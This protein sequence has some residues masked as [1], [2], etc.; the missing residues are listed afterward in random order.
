MGLGD[1]AVTRYTPTLH[2]LTNV[3]GIAAGQRHALALRSD[4]TVWAWGVNNNGQLGFGP[5]PPPPPA[6]TVVSTPGQVEGLEGVTIVAITAGDNHSVAL[7]SEGHVWAWGLNT[8]YQLGDGTTADRNRPVL[9]DGL[10]GIVAIGSGPGSNHN[11]AIRGGDRAVLAWGSNYYGTLGDGTTV[12]RAAPVT[13]I[14][15]TDIVAVG[16][17]GF[18][19]T[20]AGQDGRLWSWGAVGQ[21]GDGS[22]GGTVHQR[23]PLELEPTGITRTSPGNAASSGHALALSNDGVIWSWGYGASH[24]IGDG[25]VGGPSYTRYRPV[26]VTEPGFA[27]KVASPAI[28]PGGTSPLASVVVSM[29]AWVPAGTPAATIR[30]TTNGEEPDAFSDVYAGA[31]TFTQTVAV[32][33]KAWKAGLADSN[34]ETMTYNVEAGMPTFTPSGGTYTTPQSVAMSGTS[35]GAVIRYTTDGSEPDGTSTVYTAPVNLTANTT[36][37]AKA[38]HANMVTSSTRTA[39]YNFNFPAGGAPVFSP[40]PGTSVGSV[41][42]SM[43]GPVGATLQYTTDGTEP[44]VTSTAYSSPLT[45]T[46]TTTLKAKSFQAAQSPS[47]TT[48]GVYTIELAAPTFSPAGGTLTP[49]QAV[50]LNHADP[51]VAIRY[52]INGVDPGPTDAVAAPGSSV[53]LF[54]NATLK[55]RAYK[56]GTEPSAVT[57][58]T[59][60]VSGTAGAAGVLAAGYSHTLVA[61]PDGTVWA[62][63]SNNH[64]KLGDGSTTPRWSPVAIPSLSGVTGLSAGFNHSAARK[65]DGTPWTTGYNSA[66]QLGN[67]TNSPHSTFAGLAKPGGV[68]VIAV[69]AGES[70]TLALGSDGRVWAWGLNSYGQ[71]GNGN[72]APQTTPVLVGGGLSGVPVQAIAAGGDFS[73][74][75]T[76]GGEVWSWG[77]NSEGELGNGGTTSSNVPVQVTTVATTNL[78]GVVGI[79]AGWRH[80]LAR[81]ADGTVWS[82]GMNSEGQLGSGAIG[83]P[84]TRAGQVV[85]LAQARAIGAGRQHSLAVRDDGSVWAW[86]QGGNGQLGNNGGGNQP[87]PVQAIGISG[88]DSVAGGGLFSVALGLDGSV[89]AWGG[90]SDGQLGDGTTASR[91]TPARVSDSNFTWRVGTPQFSP[92]SGA[93]TSAQNVVITTSTAGATIHYTKTGADPSPADPAIASGASVLVDEPVTLKARAYKS[94]WAPSGVATLPFTLTLVSPT[95]TPGAGTY[96]VPQVF[97]ASHPVPGAVVRYT[98]DGSPV[99]ASSPEMP[100]GGVAVNQTMSLSVGAFK[101]GGWAASSQSSYN[102]HMKVGQT[103]HGTAGGSHSGSVNVGLASQTPHAT[104]HA[105]RGQPGASSSGGSSGGAVGTTGGLGGS[106]G[107]TQVGNS[108]TLRTEGRRGGWS[109]SQRTSASYFIKRGAAG[110]ASFSLGPQTSTGRYLSISSASPLARTRYTLDGSEPSLRSHLYRGP[111]RVLP[112]TTFRARSFLTDHSPGVATGIFGVPAPPPGEAPLSEAEPPSFSPPGGTYAT[113][114]TVTLTSDTEGASIHYT[115][116][117]SE[118]TVGSP[119]VASG[120][121][122]TVTRGLPLKARAIAGGMS[123]SAVSRADYRIT[124]AIT[125]S[126]HDAYNNVQSAMALR[127]DGT[128]WGWGSNSRGE[129]GTG[130]TT[131]QNAPVLMPGITNVSGVA[132]GLGH[133]LAVKNDGTVWSWGQ[134]GQGQLGDGTTALRLTPAVVPNLSNI[135]AVAATAEASFALT[136]TGVVFAWGSNTYGQLGIAEE[137]PYFTTPQGVSSLMDV[138]E[139]SGGTHHVLALKRDGTVWSWGL[140][141]YGQFGDG[142]FLNAWAH[143]RVGDIEGVTT[144]HAAGNQSFASKSDG[145]EFGQIW[146]W[147]YNQNNTL[148]DDM[149]ADQSVPVHVFEGAKKISGG[150]SLWSAYVKPAFGGVSELWASGNHLGSYLHASGLWSSPYPVPVTT[151]NFVQ[152]S[153]TA[154]AHTALRWDGTLLHWGSGYTA[155]NG[156]VLG[157]PAWAD[158]DHDADGLRTAHEWDLGTDPWNADSNGD[159][160]ADGTP[161][162]PTSIRSTP[163]PTLTASRTSSSARWAPTRSAPTPTATAIRTARTRFR[164]IPRAGRGRRRTEETRQRRSSR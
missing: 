77:F 121:T 63:G 76:S 62:W 64:G 152:V 135:V 60:T 157:D 38:F 163:M 129:L 147:G 7:D 43:T 73:L 23:V 53:N 56:I 98:T 18:I 126:H 87:A 96:H 44:T 47:A 112:G 117:G 13:V 11:L 5:A 12:V 65:S 55:A 110:A 69:A 164:S 2:P 146:A 160:I 141:N 24:Q 158:T 67:G 92:S 103:S 116:D 70:H 138:I 106:A 58:G 85:Q 25:Y 50:N 125:A 88:I 78:S 16:T 26:R 95:V 108:T 154:G 52:T 51:A 101:S 113:R 144:I 27:R 74:A 153:G 80:S 136:S 124:G 137:E 127:T 145:L 79:A 57:S 54:A 150:D 49:G 86:G 68:D 120:S 31:L 155:V 119:S 90:N 82:W 148:G 97:T 107:S 89:W 100:P 48:T 66:G 91:S 17:N 114:R 29:T 1:P 140:N 3:T 14:G 111:I 72:N 19:S 131:P 20:A 99:G 37:K 132:L 139:I 118:P 30:Y 149:Q 39:A 109:V 34:T 162:A 81:K 159:G 28:N 161:S 142:T 42:V 156:F 4:G 36:L 130:N 41:V 71:L 61:K 133:G 46:A 9:V 94:D 84:R 102:M 128:L 83:S 15:L 6:T 10:F 134:N 75:L 32:K 33:A 22:T 123:D 151:G 143:V 59:F 35:A 45:F 8:S 40:L 105:S 122:V 104:V 21:V 93:H 115:T